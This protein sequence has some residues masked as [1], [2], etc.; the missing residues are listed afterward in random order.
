MEDIK[1][2]RDD[3]ESDQSLLK[4]MLLSAVYSVLLPGEPITVES[5]EKDLKSMFFSTRRYDL[6]K[7]GRYKLNKK[8][9]Y[10]PQ[11]DEQIL[12]KEDIC[13]TMLYLIRVYI[14][15]TNVD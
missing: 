7:V 13:N 10:E 12:L 8:Y 6:G 4:R 5:A 9:D 3:S 15:E 1:Y 14:G 2:V 11:R